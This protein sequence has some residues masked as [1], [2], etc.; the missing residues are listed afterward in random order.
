MVLCSKCQFKVKVR[1]LKLVC[2]GIDS[3]VKVVEN[4]W[5][6]FVYQHSNLLNSEATRSIVTRMVR[7]RPGKVVTVSSPSTFRV[8]G[9]PKMSNDFALFAAF[10]K[11]FRS[12]LSINS[13]LFGLT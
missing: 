6:Q 1:E 2:L 5:I 12:F 7:T 9:F 4:S 3:F 11:T 10:L 8:M 13:I